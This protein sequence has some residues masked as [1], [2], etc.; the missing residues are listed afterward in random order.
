MEATVAVAATVL[1][2]FLTL[3]TVAA[4]FDQ[5]KNANSFVDSVS[6]FLVPPVSRLPPSDDRGS[7]EREQ[8]HH[9]PAGRA[10]PGRGRP[11][12]LQAGAGSAGHAPP[13]PCHFSRYLIS[14][15][16]AGTNQEGSCGENELT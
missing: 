9:P 1:A 5:P 6:Y 11:P 16:G 15:I 2:L 4:Q 3:D 10:V 14:S 13:V 8:R 7:G 12:R